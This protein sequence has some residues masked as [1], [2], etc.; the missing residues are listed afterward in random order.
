MVRNTRSGEKQAAL[1]Y[2]VLCD[3]GAKLPLTF[4]CLIY[5]VLWGCWEPCQT[6]F[7]ARP[8]HPLHSLPS[9]M[10][11]ACAVASPAPHRLE[12]Q[13]HEVRGCV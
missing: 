2:S 8:P 7:R 10:S 6:V 13:L 5:T 4:P 1:G 9:E 12:R 3:P 11:D